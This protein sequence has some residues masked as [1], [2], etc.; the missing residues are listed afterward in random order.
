MFTVLCAH[1]RKQEFRE[2][3]NLG[4]AP[5][6][7]ENWKIKFKFKLNITTLEKS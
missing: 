7:T 1:N 2:F 3:N 4:K 5:N 6:I